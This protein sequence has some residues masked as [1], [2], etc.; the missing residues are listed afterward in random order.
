MNQAHGTIGTPMT[1]V[2]KQALELVYRHV[3]TAQADQNEEGVDRGVRESGI[4]RDEVFVTTKL[5]A[6]I[7]L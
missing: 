7:K 1:E 6:E 4:A 2:V 3:D 5:A